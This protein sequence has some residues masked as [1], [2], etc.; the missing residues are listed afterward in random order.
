ML[1]PAAAKAAKYTEADKARMWLC[2]AGRGAHEI[3]GMDRREVLT[4][5]LH[6]SAGVDVERD[7]DA[8]KRQKMAAFWR[9]P[10]LQGKDKKGIYCYGLHS[11]GTLLWQP[12]DRHAFELLP[13]MLKLGADINMIDVSNGRTLLDELVA[14]YDWNSK[15][16][17]TEWVSPRV[18]RSEDYMFRTA[19][20]NY[21]R[22]R[23]MGARHA[24]EL[25]DRTPGVAQREAAC[26]VA[27]PGDAL[28]EFS[29]YAG[30]LATKM[31]A[32]TPKEIKGAATVSPRQ[33][34]CLMRALGS[35]MFVMHAMRDEFGLPG[36]HKY[37]A[38]AMS[39]S[40]DDEYQK[41]VA[42]FSRISDKDKAV[43]VYCHSDKCFLSYNSAL[44]LLHSGK[45]RVYWMRDGIRGWKAAGYP[46]AKANGF[47]IGE[48]E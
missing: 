36:A 38:A 37:L 20:D 1:M 43:L 26:L 5:L 41:Q 2:T 12:V 8:L 14:F 10:A 27:G 15:H 23:E 25:G 29:D 21:V 31:G 34:A 32:L 45:K 47:L 33:A 11:R 44:R 17:E 48:R 13:V 6:K 40:F 16:D 9:D 18:R 19:R 30:G 35:D 24:L 42:T 7:D 22:L 4:H 46:V 39:G 28:R 3:K